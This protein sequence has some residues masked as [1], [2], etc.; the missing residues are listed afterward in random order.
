MLKDRTHER[1]AFCE[2]CCEQGD[3]ITVQYACQLCALDS[4]NV[5][6]DF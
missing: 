2:K 6:I 4:N 5:L 3:A 1:P